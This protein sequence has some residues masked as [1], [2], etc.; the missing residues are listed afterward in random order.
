MPLHRLKESFRILLYVAL[1]CL[2]LHALELWI[3]QYYDPP[4]FFH[5]HPEYSRPFCAK[6]DVISQHPEEKFCILWGTSSGHFG[7]DM[8]ILNEGTGYRWLN[9]CR[10]GGNYEEMSYEAPFF[11]VLPEKRVRFFVVTVHPML[12]VDR[13]RQSPYEETQARINTRL[14]LLAHAIQGEG[15]YAGL[16]PVGLEKPDYLEGK[17][18]RHQVI[19][20]LEGLTNRGS[21]QA[22]KYHQNSI[23][24]QSLKALITDID[25]ISENLLFLK[26]PETG[27]VRN[28]L[29]KEAE[30]LLDTLLEGY[31]VLDLGEFLG[32]EDM[33]DPIHPNK[34]GNEKI[35]RA[36]AEWVKKRDG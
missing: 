16:E 23:Q 31:E 4:E 36:L 2:S 10:G 26:M 33:Y 17:G 8:G 14:E 28:E 15:F 5:F 1:G 12:L 9:F 21:F 22:E 11:G 35:S 32:E 13:L 7:F 30:V 34:T 25:R 29:P 19:F 24:Y 18:T 3:Y 6:V 20:Q 27:T